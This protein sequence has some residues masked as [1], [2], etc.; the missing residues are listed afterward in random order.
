MV[1]KLFIGLLVAIALV[2]LYRGMS[3]EQGRIDPAAPLDVKKIL[4]VL[5]AKNLQCDSVDSY[6]PIGKSR[7]GKWDGYLARC[8]DGGRYI[9]FQ[10]PALGKLGVSSC[11]EVSFK[12]SYRCPD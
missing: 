2:L 1:A 4:A 9:Y 8:H 6:T 5:R 7:D 11:Q 10:S 3:Q 12:Y